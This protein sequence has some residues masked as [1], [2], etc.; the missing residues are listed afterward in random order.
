METETQELRQPGLWGDYQ[1]SR[2]IEKTE[3]TPG[4][5]ADIVVRNKFKVNDIGSLLLKL[6]SQE[7]GEEKSMLFA[8][9]I[10]KARIAR[11]KH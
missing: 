11:I 8:K 6:A 2:N 9:L 1:F 7:D 4:S 3:M 10:A 5:A